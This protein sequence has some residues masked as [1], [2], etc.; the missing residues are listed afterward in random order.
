[1]S[2]ERRQ[3]RLKVQRQRPVKKSRSV[4]PVERRRA[5]SG[6]SQ[7]SE[8]DGALI[9]PIEP[10]AD[11]TVAQVWTTSGVQEV[12]STADVSGDNL[13]H[14]EVVSDTGVTVPLARYGSGVQL[15]PASSPGSL[16]WD[17]GA[18]LCSTF[19][20]TSD[21]LDLSLDF[22]GLDIENA[23]NDSVGVNRAPPN[24]A[25]AEE[26][27]HPNL[28][29]IQETSNLTE[30]EVVSG[31][32]DQEVFKERLKPLNKQQRVLKRSLN[33]FTADDVTLEDKETYKERLSL[34]WDLYIKLRD[35][36]DD[37]ASEL[38]EEDDGELRM[39]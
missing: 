24:F 9:S 29:I 7:D 18:D 12:P 19:K 4:P 39:F 37:L 2:E 26:V 36:I 31:K 35:D 34:V 11:K 13:S 6:S 30:E 14:Q 3:E 38:D 1:M 28:S 33:E 27:F 8:S 17:P 21:L 23:V 32:M 16:D 15:S 5:P 25:I 10:V 20:D 22:G